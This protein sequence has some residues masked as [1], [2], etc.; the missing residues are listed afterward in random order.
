MRCQGCSKGCSARLTLLETGINVEG[1]LCKKGID[2]ILEASK[3]DRDVYKYYLPVK[4]GYMKHILIISEHPI[5][6]VYFDQLDALLSKL[7]AEAPLLKNE[8]ILVNPLGL[9][10]KLVAARSLKRRV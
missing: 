2:Y 5:E 1:C 10:I 3:N 4:N 8:A 6:R 9:N 7:S